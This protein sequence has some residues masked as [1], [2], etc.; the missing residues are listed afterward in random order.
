MEDRNEEIEPCRDIGPHEELEVIKSQAVIKLSPVQVPAHFKR[1]ECNTNLNLPPLNWLTTSQSSHG[2]HQALYQSAGFASFRLGQMFPDCVGEVDVVSDAENIKQLLKLPYSDAQS[3][4]SMVVHKVGNTLLLDEFDIQKYLL[5]KADDDWK[6]LRSFILEH[7]LTY[8]DNQA[9]Y[10]L[11]E[12]NREALQTKN[13]LSKFLYHSLKQTGEAGDN[14]EVSTSTQ[15]TSRRPVGLP[16]SGPVLPEPKIEENVPDPK[17]S[18]AFNRNVVWTFEDIRM[19]IGT[20]MPI[21]G[22]PNRPCISLRL[23]DAA[24]PINVLTGIDYWLDNL[25][26]NVPEVVM[27]YHLDGI[28]Q[29]YEIIKTED[30]P[31]L[32]N[33]Q[34]SPQVVRNVAQ[35]ILAFLKAN[36]T[37]A[38]HTYWLFKGRNDDVVKLYDLTTLC[39]NQNQG[40]A[41]GDDHHQHQESPEKQQQMNPFTVPVGMLLYSVARN[42]KNTLKNISPQTAGNIRA[43]LDNCI[44]LLPKEQYPQIVSSSHYILS[45]L[46][47][48]AGIDP[49]SPKFDEHDSDSLYDDDED[50]EEDEDDD[51]EEDY[52][53]GNCDFTANKYYQSSEE[54][55]GKANVAVRHICDALRDFKSHTKKSKPAPLMATTVE[56]CQIS[57]EHISA[58]IS[59]LQY[60]NG[61]QEEKL[62]E[63]ETHAKQEERERILHEEQNPNM[64][65][66]FNAIPLPYEQLIMPPPSQSSSSSSKKSTKLHKSDSKSKELATTSNSSN[67]LTEDGKTNQQLSAKFNNHH[68]GSWNVHLKLLLLEKACLT[69][70]TLAEHHYELESFGCTLRA[71]ELACRC[72]QVLNKYMANVVSQQSCLLGRAGDCFFQM[73]KHWSDIAKYKRQYEQENEIMRIIGEE[74]TQELQQDDDDELPLSLEPTDNVEQVMLLSCKCYEQALQHS[75]KLESNELL[76]RLGNVRNEL[77][78]KYMYWAQEEYSEYMKK[79]E[80]HVRKYGRKPQKQQDEEKK[81]KEKPLY[82]KLTVNSYDCLRRG[83]KAFTTVEDNI[84]LAFLYCN[85]GRFMRLR[86]HLTMPDESAVKLDSQKTFYNEAFKY[87]EK[88]KDCLDTRKANAELW[89]LVQWELSTATF[90]LAKQLQDHGVTTEKSTLVE[91]TKEVLELLQKSLRLCDVEHAGARQVLYSFRSGLIHRRI[92]SFH[93]SQLRAAGNCELSHLPKS[94]LQLCKHHYEKAAQILESLKEVQ[95]LLIVQLERISLHE[96]LAELTSY[97]AQKI[98]QMQAALDICLQCDVI[99]ASNVIDTIISNNTNNSNSSSSNNSNYAINNSNDEFNIHLTLFESR[100]QN[101]L[102]TLTKLLLTG[103]DSKQLSAL[104]KRMYMETLTGKHGTGEQLDGE[105]TDTA[106]VLKSQLLHTLITRLKTMCEAHMAND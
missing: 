31:Y 45:D 102:K 72:Q 36:A 73:S 34:F 79:K 94:S 104:Y 7:I 61:N 47:I 10:C 62:K 49:K 91:S 6:W 54:S 68:F 27:C 38:G 35:N 98:K 78:L 1:L 63:T 30:L 43:L 16:I 51:E 76:R 65:K 56:R 46:H 5:R 58:G 19:L 42:M 60:F 89:D 25:M 40:G 22:G 11:K 70:A 99:V 103:K 41:G 87:Y 82:V 44:K 55:G 84:N 15:V 105:V 67:S 9:N 12:R 33:S 95:E 50:D 8:G 64:A 52:Q 59:C 66:P 28:V 23:R 20:D 29:K 17:S 48:P 74:I 93:Y 32:E 92:A 77:G 71:I 4:I 90:T 14:Y 39:E 96:Y 26:C 18:H 69:Y 88:A 80:E 81:D 21:F 97:S 106:I 100:I 101:A 83:I 53:Y 75:E 3:A 13:L 24:Q 37:K 86:A 57:L 2:L 85:M